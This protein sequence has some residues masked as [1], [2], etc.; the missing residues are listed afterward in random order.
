MDNGLKSCPFCGGTGRLKT[1]TDIIAGRIV[2]KHAVVCERCGSRTPLCNN[3]GEA[4][5]KWENRYHN[6][7]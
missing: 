3:A 4:V 2:D 1:F 6:D 5:A 7:V